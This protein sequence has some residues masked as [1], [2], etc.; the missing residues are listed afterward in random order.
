MSR[1]KTTKMRAAR[2]IT[3]GISLFV[4]AGFRETVRRV[5]LQRQH[6]VVVTGD[7][8]TMQ[9]V[10]SRF[11][12]H[13][14]LAAPVYIGDSFVGNFSYIEPYCRISS[15]TIGKFC[16]IAPFCVIGPLS[17]PLEHASTHPAFYLH[18]ER[19]SYNF[20]DESSD[21][22]QPL[23]TTIGNDVW[24]GSGVF[25]RRGITIGDGAVLGAG[26]V[27][28]KDVPAYS[29]VGGVPAKVIRMRFDEDTVKALLDLQWW[30]KDDTWLREH[31]PLFKDVPR[32]LAL[33]SRPGTSGQKR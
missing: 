25:V 33:F 21:A 10:S 19:Y 1:P 9:L 20:V 31:A 7:S 26:A 5:R 17:H 28:I 29:I 15:T 32:L 27:V 3:R 22:S 12:R 24:V 8:T 11:G 18:A 16:S 14:R 13:C 4:P 30:N 23:R 6:G 2:R